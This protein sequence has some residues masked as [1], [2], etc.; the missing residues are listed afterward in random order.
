VQ[1]LAAIEEDKEMLARIIKSQRKLP[2]S[3]TIETIKDNVIYCRSIWG[4]HVEY[5]RTDKLVE[6]KDPKT[7]EIKQVPQY[8]LNV[9]K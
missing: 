1:N 9:E 8:E 7:D 4:G 3:L 5:K 6:Y 2:Y